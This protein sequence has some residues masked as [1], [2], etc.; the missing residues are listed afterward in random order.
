MRLVKLLF[1]QA[2]CFSDRASFSGKACLLAFM[3][4]ACARGCPTK[5]KVR[6]AAFEQHEATIIE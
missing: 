4:I 2:L 6:D 1:V 3:K 5:R